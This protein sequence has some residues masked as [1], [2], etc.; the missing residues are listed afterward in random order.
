VGASASLRAAGLV[1]LAQQPT[2]SWVDVRRRRGNVLLSRI[3]AAGRGV[4][5]DGSLPMRLTIGNAA[6]TRCSSAGSLRPGARTRDNV[7]RVELQ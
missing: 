6:G 7:A 2:A 3:G 1:Q 5:L 4:G